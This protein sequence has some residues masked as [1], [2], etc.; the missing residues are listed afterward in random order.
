[1][2]NSNML[3]VNHNFYEK[4]N[5][6][7]RAIVSR[8]LINAN[9]RQDIDDCVNTVYLGLID[10]LQQYNETRGS[11]AAFIAIIA[12]STALDYC[13]S[14]ANKSDELVGD[15]KLDFFSE[16]MEFEDGVEFNILV[17]NILD[18]LN[19]QESAL[20]SMKYIYFYSAEEIAKTFGIN[21]NAVDGCVNRLKAKIKKLLRKGGIS[22]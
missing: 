21:R 4:Y 1:M 14:N 9:K 3:E 13:R 5:T 19:E 7:I 17:E 16:P 8:I 6:Q 22:I 2:E 12:R 18:K 10:K 20:F 11:M 15:E